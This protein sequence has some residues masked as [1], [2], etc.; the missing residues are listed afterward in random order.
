[1]LSLRQETENAAKRLH[2]RIESGETPKSVYT[3]KCKNCSLVQ[4]CLPKAAS[5]DLSVKNYMHNMLEKL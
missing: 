5:G 3:P 1:M 2:K 4:F